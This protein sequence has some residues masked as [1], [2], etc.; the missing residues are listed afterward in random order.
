MSTAIKKYSLAYW[1]KQALSYQSNAEAVIA[2]T[3]RIHSQDP[4][5]HNIAFTGT[6][7]ELLNEIYLEHRKRMK[8]VHLCLFPTPMSAARLLATELGIQRGQTIFDPCAGTA[9]LLTA[10][11][12]CG[13]EAHGLEIQ[14]WLPELLTDLGLAVLRGD[15]LDQSPEI[16]AFDVV[17]VNPPFGRIGNSSDA[18]TDFLARIACISKPG[19][20][21]GAILPKDHFTRGP[22]KR[23]STADRFHFHEAIDLPDGT[24]KPL[25]PV[26]TTIHLMEV[27][28]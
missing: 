19:T 2:D 20:M 22:K 15:F 6:A 5:R 23:Q 28:A 4:D 9:N 7:H 25:T 14:H 1:V 16:P 17:M 3:V 27:A 24:F 8:S 10:A 21:V 18:T 26:A 13:A 11:L 12:E